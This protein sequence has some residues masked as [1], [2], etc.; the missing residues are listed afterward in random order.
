MQSDGGKRKENIR[1]WSTN[2]TGL[3]RVV[4]TGEDVGARSP[5]TMATGCALVDSGQ[6]TYLPF[7]SPISKPASNF[8]ETSLCVRHTYNTALDGAGKKRSGNSKYG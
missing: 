1:T 8:A 4:R 3:S 2:I 7:T 6:E 5:V